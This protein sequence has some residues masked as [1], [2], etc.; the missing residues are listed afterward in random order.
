MI[1]AATEGSGPLHAFLDWAGV[2][3]TAQLF[4]LLFGLVAQGLFFLRWVVQLI[5]TERRGR[6]HVPAS[7][8]WLSLVGASML[9]IYFLLRREPVGLIG[10]GIGWI[11]YWRNLVILRREAKKEHAPARP[12]VDSS[13]E[14]DGRATGP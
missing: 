7:F 8:W 2:Q 14:P 4:L 9:T 13:V 11:V 5:A 1:A 12:P 10:Q 6:S 3:D